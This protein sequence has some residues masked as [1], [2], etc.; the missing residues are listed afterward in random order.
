MQEIH[1]GPGDRRAFNEVNLLLEDVFGV[2]IKPEDESACNPQPAP[3]QNLDGLNGIQPQVLVLF[4]FGQRLFHRT[5][6]P[7]KN[8]EEVR[9]H[10]GL[11]QRRTLGEV[12]R[13]FGVERQRETVSLLPLFQF[14]GQLQSELVIA[15][16]IIIDN[17]H[18]LFP[19][20]AQESVQFRQ[21][22]LRSEEHTSELQ[23]LAY[24]VCRL[25]LE[26]KK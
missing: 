5:L 1:H 19:S 13:S 21:Q 6:N 8:I 11:N 10:H 24:L 16:E 7:N 3:V 9:L 4:G 15:D 23:S 18:L 22:L 17:K 2:G 26:K 25:L 14:D 12:H 20:Q